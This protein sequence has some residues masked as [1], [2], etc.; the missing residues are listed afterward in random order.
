MN[1]H[2][3]FDTRGSRVDAVESEPSKALT[4]KTSL[5]EEPS[6]SSAFM[7]DRGESTARVGLKPRRQYL[8]SHV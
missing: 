4:P 1:G 8:L 3:I 5:P 2:T 6:T 7:A